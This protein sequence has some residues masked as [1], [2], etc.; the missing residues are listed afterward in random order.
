MRAEEELVKRLADL[1][2]H[3]TVAESCTGG[4]VAAHITSVP[5]SSTVVE[6]GFVTYSNRAKVKVLDV[7]KRLLRMYTEYSPQAAAAMAKGAA[8]KAGSDI[9]LA[10]TGI[11]GPD[12]GSEDRPV[13]LVYIACYV[14]RASLARLERTKEHIWHMDMPK[15]GKCVVREY[16]FGGDRDAVREQATQAALTLALEGMDY[17]ACMTDTGMEKD[18]V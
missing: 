15:K 12:G 6:Q 11:A 10:I 7:D 1:Q 8:K 18:F 17:I 4:M 3:I 5:G 2:M 16:H 9:A 14:T 13:G